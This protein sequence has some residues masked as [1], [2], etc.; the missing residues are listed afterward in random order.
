MPIVTAIRDKIAG[1]GLVPRFAVWDFGDGIN[2]PALFTIDP[3]PEGAGAP[4]A[5]ITEDPQSETWGTRDK[6]GCVANVHIAIK[7]DKTRSDRELRDLANDVY[8]E[9]NRCDLMATGYIVV[10][11]F[12]TKP[13]RT[14]DA[15][16]FPEYAIDVS[17]RIIET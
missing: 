2:R 10:S 7:G 13:Y 4:L 11:V 14:S 16:G 5:I 6:A 3:P 9:L 12:A 17:L 8:K 1:L 15:D